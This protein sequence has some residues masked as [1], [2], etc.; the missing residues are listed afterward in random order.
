MLLLIILLMVAFLAI[1]WFMFGR[2]QSK[3]S[4]GAGNVGKQ[5]YPAI[6]QGPFYGRGPQGYGG[7]Y[8]SGL[9]FGAGAPAGNG[10]PGLDPNAAAG[11]NFAGQLTNQIG[12]V[13][14]N[15]AK[16]GFATGGLDED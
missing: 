3:P 1:A 7:G 5:P 10:Q 13:F 2:K 12:N 11:W 4:Q 15:W 6:P 9:G 8:G 16:T 14:S